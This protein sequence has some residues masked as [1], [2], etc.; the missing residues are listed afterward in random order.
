MAR[1]WVAEGGD[2]LH[3]VDLDGARD[4]R[5]SNWAAIEAI[6]KAVDVPCELGGGIRDEA[7]IADLLALG[8]SR[9]VIGTKAL[10]EPEWFRAVCRRFPRRLV[11]GLDARDGRVA[12]EGWL[13]TSDVRAADLVRQ[14]EDEPLA[15]VVYTDIAVDGMLSGPNLASLEEMRQATRLPLIASGGVASADDVGR[16]ARLPVAGCILGRALYEGHLTMADA[17]VAAR[18]VSTH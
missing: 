1:R 13:Q 16:L 11:L 3:L 14:F 7:T 10:R 12:A 9:L 8:L 15:A 18:G 2:R 6:V 4:G 17:L 5:I